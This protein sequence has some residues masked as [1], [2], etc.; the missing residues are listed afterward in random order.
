MTSSDQV[1]RLLAA[2]RIEGPPPG[3]AEA[4]RARLLSSLAGEAALLPVAAGA[5]KL[6]WP[7][8]A[9]WI[10]AGFAVGIAGAGVAAYGTAPRPEAPLTVSTAPQVA[11][12]APRGVPAPVALEAPNESSIADTQVVPPRPQVSSPVVAATPSTSP[13]F[14]EELRLLTAA[15]RELNGGRPHLA[16][17]WLFEHRARFSSGV[18]GGE[19][20]GLLVLASCDERA[21]PELAREF[22]ARY[23]KSPMIGQLLRRCGAEESGKAPPQVDFPERHK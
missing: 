6:G 8:L 1:S 9:K 15:K 11:P 14:D 7:L 16:R 5:T 19:R 3:V 10:G 22:A 13:G 21:R 20:E 18:F 2:E 4:G 12:G 17:A 23:P